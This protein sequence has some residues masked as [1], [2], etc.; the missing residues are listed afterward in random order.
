MPA[1]VADELQFPLG[2]LVRMM[3]RASGAAG[4]GFYGAVPRLPPE[5]DVGTALVVLP[6]G[7]ADAVFC[8]VFQKG[9]PEPQ[10]LC[11]TDCHEECFLS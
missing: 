5:V 9:L 10:M 4:Q 11:Y 2:V 8:G 7:S 1:H 3:R 6:V